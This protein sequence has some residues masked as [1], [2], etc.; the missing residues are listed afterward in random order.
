MEV[1]TSEDVSSIDFA[2]GFQWEVEFPDFKG[3]LFPCTTISDTIIVFA[4]GSITHGPGEFHYPIMTGRGSMSMQ[5]LETADRDIAS[6]LHEWRKDIADED[7][8]TVGLLGI[9]N[10][11][12]ECIVYDIHYNRTP[13]EPVTHLKV[14][15]DG[16]V[17]VE[18]T[19]EKDGLVSIG[20]NFQVVGEM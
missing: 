2:H 14:V 17:Q 4:S 20:V 5:I 18:R 6:W 10:V 9:P 1:T 19:S 16:E 13:I 12:R 3:K 7:N 15:P 11:A 8:Y